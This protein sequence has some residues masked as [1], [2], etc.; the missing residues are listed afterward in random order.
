MIER[1]E[2]ARREAARA[3]LAAQ[4]A[5]RLRVARELHDEIGQTLTAVT[6]QA[7]RAADDDSASARQELR[8]VA[9]A[10]RESLDEVRRIARELRPE[11]LDDLGLVNALIALCRRI[12]TQEDL[13]VK[14]ELQTTLPA[15]PPD[16]E[17]VVYRIAQESLTNALRHS[18]AS[19]ASVSLQADE[20]LLILGI[21][22]DGRGMPAELPPGT[23]GIA[24]MRERAL[25][26]GGR[27]SMESAPGG[28]TVVRL[29][30]PVA[31]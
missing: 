14:R 18:G 10:V 26:V 27:L 13:R 4:E 29:T 22:D 30:V 17:L 6:I 12:E 23:G 1:L 15:L 5:E 20:R 7:E 21:A 31:A 11:A 25:L 3:A 8:R 2:S 9:D 19:H 24:G 28:G 16:V